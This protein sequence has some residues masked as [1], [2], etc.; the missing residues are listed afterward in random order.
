MTGAVVSRL[1]HDNLTEIPT[2]LSVLREGNL[3]KAVGSPNALR[4]LEILVGE[5]MNQDLPLGVA[6][7]CSTCC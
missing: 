4:Q 6:L 1:V 5:K 2:P 7:I 3:I